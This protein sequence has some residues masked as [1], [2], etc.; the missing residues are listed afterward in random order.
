VLEWLKETL[1][2]R[3]EDLLY[4]GEERRILLIFAGVILA[5]S[6][7][8]FA[9]SQGDAHGASDVGKQIPILKTSSPSPTEA[10]KVVVDVAGKVI[11]PGVYT[12]PSPARAIDAIKAAGGARKGVDLS[13]INLAHILIDGEQILVGAPKPVVSKRG[14]SKK[15]ATPTSIGINSATAGQFDSLPGIGPVMAARIVAYRTSHGAF[16]SI[17]DLRKVPGMGKSKFENLKAY[18]HL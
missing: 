6:A 10:A 14:S 16:T 18:I 13:D 17:D 15:V 11:K 12:L 7:H 8:F 5:M 2:Q 1:R 3:M 9:L 4:S